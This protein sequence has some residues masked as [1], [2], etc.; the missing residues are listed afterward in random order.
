MN[1]EYWE[2]DALRDIALEGIRERRRARRWS[3]FFRFL[4]LGYLVLLL[5]MARGFDFWLGGDDAPGPH[6]AVVKINGALLPDGEN[7]AENIIRGLQNAYRDERTAGVILQVNSPGG[8][9]VQS[10]QINAEIR[11]L[12]ARYPDMPIYTVAEDM[13]TSG[14][15]YAAVS[16]D[17]IYVD[18]G[19][20]IGS[21]GV[22]I[23]SF[24]FHEA[25]DRLGIERRLYT[26]GDSKGF[27]DPFSAAEPEDEAWIEGLLTDVHEQFI[28]AVKTGRGDRLAD[29]DRLFSGLV[30]TGEQGVELGLADELG[31][32][33]HVAREVIGVEEIRDFTPQA[34]VLQ[35]FAGRIGVSI[36]DRLA[37]SLLGDYIVR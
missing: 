31:S 3:I 13:F 14:A 21:I 25:M 18:Q 7:R 20:L 8:S 22:L 19:T 37:S 6:T 28:E 9:P 23:N 10:G 17:R 27:L 32:L 1:D 24:G 29:D 35:R 12:K 5:L 2:R 30:W 15:Y 11:R 33:G 34:G 16:T 4:F 36:G 26:A